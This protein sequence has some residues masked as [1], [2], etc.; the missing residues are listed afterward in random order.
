M[1]YFKYPLEDDPNRHITIATTRPE[2]MLGDVAI[3]VHPDDERY[4]DVV[5]RVA[6]QPI[7]QRA[8]RIIADPFADPEQGSGAVKITPA[9]DFNDFEIGQKYQLEMIVIFDGKA[10]CNDQCPE[11]YQ[12][13]ERYEAR[14][15]IIQE[16]KDKGFFEKEEKHMHVVPYG[17]RG[18]VPVEPLLTEQ[19]FVKADDLA[20]NAH[21]SVKEGRTKIFPKNWE[22][23]YFRWLEDIQP[24][25]ISRQLWWG[26]RIPAWYGE[27]GKIFVAYDEEEAVKMAQE[28]YQK[29]DVVLTQD[30]DVLDTWFSSALWPFSTLGWP[31]D[32]AILKRHY[33]TDI[34][35]TGFDILFFWVARMM[36]MGL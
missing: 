16:M 36:M 2:T 33:P 30:Q 27:D 10:V 9:H 18:R 23:T 19:W 5:G 22:N 20:K 35:V 21:A 28:Y 8:C 14:E 24:W 6:L 34:L 11:R 12:G 13:L 29:K 31:E 1:W 25:C 3:V 4:K 26:H 7:T 15:K 32:H 17:D